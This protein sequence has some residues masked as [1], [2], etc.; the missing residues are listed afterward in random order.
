M[1][2]SD[3][4]PLVYGVW[5]RGKGWLRDGQHKEFGDARR[6][7]ADCAARH[8]GQGAEVRYIDDSMIALEPLFLEREKRGLVRKIMRCLDGIQVRHKKSSK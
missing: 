5:I 2:M 7:Y 8:Y 4:M 1:A 6:E 3:K